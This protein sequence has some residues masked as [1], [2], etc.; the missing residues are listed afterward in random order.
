MD[1]AAG[2]Q[3]IFDTGPIPG[4]TS[5]T[6]PIDTIRADTPQ[7]VEAAFAAMEEAKARGYWLTGYASY[8]LGYVF[9]HKLRDR[10]PGKRTLPLVQFGVFRAPE[11]NR[12]APP[13]Q[14][15]ALGDLQPVWDETRYSRAFQQ[16]QDYIAAGDIYQA[17]LTF[18]LT[19]RYFGTP[20]DLYRTLLARQPVPYG[21]FVDLGGP[22]LLSRSPELF[23]AVDA[24]GHIETHPMKGTAARGAT[25]DEDAAQIAWLRNSEKN[26]A[27]NLMIVDL[28]RN[29]LSK[30]AEVGSVKV[31]DL[32]KIETYVTLHQMISRIVARLL[33]DVTLFDIFEGLFPCGSI[34]GAPKIRAMQILRDLEPEERGPYCGA[35]GWI[36]PNG[37]MQFNVAIRTVVCDADG[38]ARLSVGGG[39]VHDSVASEE[40]AEALLKSRFACVGR[41]DCTGAG[42]AATDEPFAPGLVI[43]KAS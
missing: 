38:Q 35:I 27:E 13:A 9:S 15:A 10:I 29:D 24:Q 12:A 41:D 31:P 30:L 3:V 17:N 14:P 33:P 23:F 11:P 7:E 19:A 43:P 4:G 28:M 1:R 5:F 22:T 39:V 42:Q 40:Y 20:L 2:R 26:R 32:F 37:A 34:T 25:P 6:D 36:A 18:P 16:V 8:E 21:A